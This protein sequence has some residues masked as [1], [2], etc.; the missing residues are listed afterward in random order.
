MSRI[1]AWRLLVNFAGTR[2]AL[3]ESPTNSSVAAISQ[4]SA[5]GSHMVNIQEATGNLFAA[6]LRE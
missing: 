6:L 4:E 2:E 5:D 1:V 3:A